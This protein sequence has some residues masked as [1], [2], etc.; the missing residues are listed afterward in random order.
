[1]DQ[2]TKTTLDSLDNPAKRRVLI[3]GGGFAGIKAALELAGTFKFEV[4]LLSDQTHFRYYPMLYRTATGGSQKA[5]SIPLNEIFTGKDLAIVQDI[6]KTLERS[7]KLVKG[8]SGKTY[9]YDILIVAL[10]SVTNFFGV[11]G[12]REHSFGI[13]TI[14]EAQ[15]FRNHLHQQL[16]D[17]QRPDLNYVVIGGGA[18]GVELAGVLPGYI[19]HIMKRHGLEKRP[20]SVDLVEAEKRLMPRMGEKYSAKIAKRLRSLGIKLFL[21][22]R[23]LAESAEKLKISGRTLASET[24]VWTAGV[25]VNPFL[26]D[27]NFALSKHGKVA[28][29]DYLQTETDIFVIG[30]NADTRYSGMAQTALREGQY[31]AR[32]LKAL[33]AGKQL[34]TYQPKRPVY[35]TPVGRYWAGVSWRKREYFGPIG[36]LLR[37]AADLIAYHEYEPWWLASKRWMAENENEESCPVCSKN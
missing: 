17:D 14:E 6:A 12:L 4:T 22:Q 2:L 10:G 19:K 24:V 28:V 3:L 13:K 36:W 16:L 31:V 30:D 11:R 34:K 33:A 5:S 25:A 29:D 18:T 37:R 35:V 15:H 26:A 7:K 23:V 32:Y 1:M 20:V 8:E 21:N 27:N 9:Q